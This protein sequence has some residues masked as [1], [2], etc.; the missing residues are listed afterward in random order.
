[1]GVGFLAEPM[2]HC[3][4]VGQVGE[5]KEWDVH[6]RIV[7]GQPLDTLSQPTGAGTQTCA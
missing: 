2:A 3:A 4:R 1:M 6:P 5:G 7:G